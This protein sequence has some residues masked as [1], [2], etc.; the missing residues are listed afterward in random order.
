MSQ[1]EATPIPKPVEEQRHQ[2]INAG[3]QPE[4]RFARVGLSLD[5]LTNLTSDGLRILS[6]LGGLGMVI[7]YEN[8]YVDE[9]LALPQEWEIE[10]FDGPE[11]IP[12]D[13]FWPMYYADPKGKKALEEHV[14]YEFPRVLSSQGAHVA[15]SFEEEEIDGVR[16][17]YMIV[18]PAPAIEIKTK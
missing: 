8:D 14:T 15:I 3:V 17:T 4:D 5:T 1:N 10:R 2:D 6:P 12:E 9:R 13:E 7:F 16:E 18:K 11:I